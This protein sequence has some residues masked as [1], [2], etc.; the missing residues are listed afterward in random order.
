MC[1]RRRPSQREERGRALARARAVV[2]PPTCDVC[3][4]GGGAAGLTAALAAAEAGARV[5]LVEASA[6]PGR[7]I[8][9]TGNGRCNLTNLRLADA[10]ADDAPEVAAYR[11]RAFARAVMGAD[12]LDAILGLFGRL[13]LDTLDEQG[14]VY[15]A[16]LAAASVRSLLVGACERAGVLFACGRVACGLRRCD[17]GLLQVSWDDGARG[18]EIAARA[19]VC[20]SGGAYTGARDAQGTLGDDLARLGLAWTMPA[21]VLCP[22]ACEGVPA[23]L[24]GRRARAELSLV[25]AGLVVAR[26]AGELLFRGY[27][28]SGIAVF[29]LSR[30]AHSGDRVAVD[31]LPRYD[32][33]GLVD[34]LRD[35][36]GRGLGLADAAAGLMDPQ[37]GSYLAERTS[38]VR[39]AESARQEFARLAKGWEF[40][41]TGVADETHAQ[42]TRGGLGVESLDPATLSVRDARA[43]GLYA[44]GEAVDVDGPCGGYNLSWAWLSGLRAGSCAARHAM[45][46][47]TGGSN[48][49]RR[50]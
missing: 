34:H 23:E 8:L 33:R 1:A 14:R 22:L 15:P 17:D 38:Q 40:T 4:V 25:R 29:D 20:A 12:P 6:E 28:L 35:L 48:S 10:L 46:S 32:A 44:C 27:G 31:L 37:V 47:S 16:S 42:V 50:V 18:G 21:H 24:D 43:A 36:A 49:P 26:E 7:T 3:V 41:V 19:V 11:N 9:A 39:T 13:G 45:G 30:V 2:T 5:V